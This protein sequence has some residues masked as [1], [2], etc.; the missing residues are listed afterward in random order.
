MVGGGAGP[1]STW[2]PVPLLIGVLS[3]TVAVLQVLHSVLVYPSGQGRMADQSICMD[4][5]VLIFKNAI[6]L[7]IVG[8]TDAVLF[9]YLAHLRL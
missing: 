4:S 7:I 9:L 3:Q 1:Y 6:L 5:T 8:C 2:L